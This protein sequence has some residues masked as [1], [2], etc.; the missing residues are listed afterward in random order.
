MDN[1]D[2]QREIIKEIEGMKNIDFNKST[3]IKVIKYL[4]SENVELSKNMVTGNIRIPL[5]ILTI[6]QLTEVKKIYMTSPYTDP[7]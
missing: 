6:K 1:S 7:Y 5:E 2:K 4:D 3:I